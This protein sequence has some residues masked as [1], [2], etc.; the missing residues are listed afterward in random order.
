MDTSIGTV[1]CQTVWRLF[2]LV[3]LL[4]AGL[5]ERVF[6]QYVR[7]FSFRTEHER[8]LHYALDDWI[9]YTKARRITSVT[10]G[11]QYIYFGSLDGGIL[12]YH[13]Y[14]EHWDYPYTTSN[15]LPEN[16][17]Y[18]VIF[19]PQTSLLWAITRRDTA[20]FD[21]ARQEWI[22]R[23][24]VGYWPYRFPQ[25]SFPDT[26]KQIQINRFYDARFLK[27]LPTFFANG[28]FTITGDWRLVDPF[29]REFPIIGF[30]RDQW[31]RIWFLVDKFGIGLGQLYSS[32]ADF[33]PLGLS[34]IYPLALAFQGDDL[35]IGGVWQRIDRPGIVYWRNHDG[36]WEYFEARWI[37]QLPSDE[38]TSIQVQGDSVWFGTRYGVSLYDRDRG[39]WYNF[40]LAHG[41]WSN[42]VN[43]IMLVGKHLFIATDQGVNVI[44]VETG[45][46]KRVTDKR[47][48]NIPINRLARQDDT[49]WAAT[50]RG[51]FRRLPNPPRWE[52]V[53]SQAALSDVY[54]TA[55]GSFENEVWFSTPSGIMWLDVK[56][57][58]WESFPQIGM[59]IRGRM[60]DIKVNRQSVWIATEE[61]LLKYDKQRRYWRL[62]TTN[63]GLLDNYCH[64]V[65]LD[66]D[67]LWVATN[68]GITQ[69]YWNNPARID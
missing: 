1:R 52:W 16:A 45:L 33:F 40:N 5:P 9:S 51:I 66:G 21:A 38:V 57:G 50:N 37:S 61:G 29:F 3:F 64:F 67:Y 32:R 43:D 56:T 6:S 68:S 23:S 10:M 17:V 41:L 42:Q 12:R 63:D 62:Y 24:Q 46:V 59:E 20:V 30:M 34:D 48:R 31:D 15:G 35:W 8:R 65:L 58:R 47:L 44:D 53:P 4:M 2:L 14:E 18:N 69:F 55:V 25:I 54:I 11:T 7:R 39:R 49:L 19:D 27:L 13:L 60:R 28:P 26:G 36:G 22:S